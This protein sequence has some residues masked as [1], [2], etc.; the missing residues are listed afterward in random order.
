[1]ETYRNMALHDKKF[2]AMAV[3]VLSE[4]M[5]S[6]GLLEERA[7]LVALARISQKHPEL[8]TWKEAVAP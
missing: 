8:N 1:M 6:K 3:P 7:C 5:A 2:A 4:F